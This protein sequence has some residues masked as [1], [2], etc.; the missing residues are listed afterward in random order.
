MKKPNFPPFEHHVFFEK[1]RF[2][3]LVSAVKEVAKEEKRQSGNTLSQCLD[4][5]AKH[6]GFGN[7]SLLMKTLDSAGRYRF[8]PETPPE[9]IFSKVDN[10]DSAVRTA[11]FKAFPRGCLRFAEKD[12]Y[13]IIATDFTPVALGGSSTGDDAVIRYLKSS[14]EEIYPREALEH[15]VRYVLKLGPWQEDEIHFDEF[16]SGCCD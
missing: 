5:V 7:W 14:L 11:V 1:H 4:L 9:N 8:D 10:L 6:A 15:A 12:A 3:D 2:E 13:S 16:Y